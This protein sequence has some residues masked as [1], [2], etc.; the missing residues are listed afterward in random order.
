MKF[1]SARLYATEISDVV[2][3]LLDQSRPNPIGFDSG[4][5]PGEIGHRDCA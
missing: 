2:E 5:G 4:F 3:F 1:L